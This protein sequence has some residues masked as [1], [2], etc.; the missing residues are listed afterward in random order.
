MPEP[1]Q[2]SRA[3]VC[4]THKHD[5]AMGIVQPIQTST[6]YYYLD[7]G[8][9]P[10]PRYFNT[11]NQDSVAKKIAELENAED[12]LVFASGMAAISTSV[13][14]LVAPSDHV[15]LL[16]GL[17]GGTHSFLVNELSKWGVEFDFAN[18][19]EKFALMHRSNTVLALVESASTE[20]RPTPH[21]RAT[22]CHSTTPAD[23]TRPGLLGERS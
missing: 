23:R 6:A 4:V 22:A 21:P 20:S 13:M 19:V 17:Y 1:K 3:S 14:S 11:L 8:P 18:S 15:L 12:G 10:Y 9:Q 2:I 7:E 16:S 5:P